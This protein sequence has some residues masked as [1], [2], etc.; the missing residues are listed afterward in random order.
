MEFET[1]ADTVVDNLSIV[2]VY[3]DKQMDD[4]FTKKMAN[5]WS[6]F[7]PAPQETNRLNKIDEENL[8]N[9]IWTTV[10]LV[11]FDPIFNIWFTFIP[12]EYQIRLFIFTMELN[13]T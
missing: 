6:A 7:A 2:D 13:Y 5:Q 12:V 1:S 8:Q 9:F 4:F 3:S 11:G 10:V